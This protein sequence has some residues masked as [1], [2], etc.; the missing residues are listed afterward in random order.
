MV[1]SVPHDLLRRLRGPLS[2]KMAEADRELL[3]GLENVGVKLDNGEDETGFFLKL[4][5][6]LGGCYV[7]VGHPS[8]SLKAR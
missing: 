1:A 5:R 6:Y 4:V 8:L 3:Q 2:K 7:D